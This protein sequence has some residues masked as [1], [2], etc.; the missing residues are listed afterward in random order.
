MFCRVHKRTTAARAFALIWR[1]RRIDLDTT[2][3]TIPEIQLVVATLRD[4]AEAA[5]YHQ[6][7]SWSAESWAISASGISSV[8]EPSTY[9]STDGSQKIAAA[10]TVVSTLKVTASKRVRVSERNKMKT[11]APHAAAEAATIRTMRCRGPSEARR[12]T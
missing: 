9:V 11:T 2:P 7:G 10:V 6:S 12:S 3:T 4:A 5:T 1:A 8:A